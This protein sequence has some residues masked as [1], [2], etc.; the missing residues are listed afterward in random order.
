MV[1]FCKEVDKALDAKG[2]TAVLLKAEAIKAGKT[3]I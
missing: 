1:Y 3:A 2:H